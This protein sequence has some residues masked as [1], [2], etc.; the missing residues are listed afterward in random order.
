MI[1]NINFVSSATSS[2]GK[3]HF[4]STMK[5][6]SNQQQ[7]PARH[8]TDVASSSDWADSERPPA[9]KAM[10][11]FNDKVL[12]SVDVETITEKTE[13]DQT[14]AWS[15]DSGDFSVGRSVKKKA[16]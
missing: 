12:D 10:K 16:G 11:E 13:E 1:Q 8:S 4:A 2:P 5:T 6:P 14:S 9:R 15:D 3:P 7:A